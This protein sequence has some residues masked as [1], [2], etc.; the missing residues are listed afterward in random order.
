M[1]INAM[2][3]A[4]IG[5]RSDYP[6]LGTQPKTIAARAQAASGEP[7]PSNTLTTAIK[8]ISTYIPTETLTLYVAL[9]AALQT[10]NNNSTSTNTYRW[11]AFWIF[12]VFTP[13]A[14]WITY[15]TKMVSDN[16]KMPLNPIYWPAWEMIAGTI[17]YLAWAYG[18]PNSVFGVF[19]WYSAPIAGF[20]VLVTSTLLGML[21]GLFQQPLKPTDKVK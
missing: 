10:A 9:I 7:T 4:A 21:A 8:T 5:R 3:N 16:K 13:L 6:P 1:S 12:L 17:A 20:F 11:I 2:A 18:L 15:A 14:I 19:T